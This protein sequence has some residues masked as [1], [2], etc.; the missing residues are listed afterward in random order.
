M[1]RP[2]SSGYASCSDG[3]PSVP[4]SSSC[5]PPGG[6]ELDELD[7]EA[8]ERRAR[9]LRTRIRFHTT[10][11]ARAIS[12]AP[13]PSQIVRSVESM[14]RVPRPRLWP[15]PHAA[16]PRNTPA[17]ASRLAR[18]DTT[19][20]TASRVS[21]EGPARGSARATSRDR[22]RRRPGSDGRTARE[23]DSWSSRRFRGHSA[24]PNAMEGSYTRAGAM[25]R[26]RAPPRHTRR[27]ALRARAAKE[28]VTRRIGQRRVRHE[29]RRDCIEHETD[30]EAER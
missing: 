10:P 2:S 17:A 1:S 12:A 22:R 25:A 13:S 11:A 27:S 15:K 19:Q 8:R 24:Q 16:R 30:R 28:A 23:K 7:D 21:A 9:L 4:A 18:Q 14:P 5:S 6:G 26:R 29:W 20:R 3:S